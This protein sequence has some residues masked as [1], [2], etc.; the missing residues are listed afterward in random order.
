MARIRT[1]RP[2]FWESEKVGRLSPLARLTFVGLISLAD[3]EGRGRGS[4]SFLLGRLHP[5]GGVSLAEI[6]AAASEI[7]DA[8]LVQWYKTVD[9]CEFYTLPGFKDNQYIERPSK[10]KIPAPPT[11]KSS[12]KTPRT[13]GEGSPQ[14]GKGREGKG[15]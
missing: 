10:S 3:D 14:E 7:D 12:P 1:I 5:Y 13:V 9:G 2:E 6:G 11:R 4:H 15:I 8:G